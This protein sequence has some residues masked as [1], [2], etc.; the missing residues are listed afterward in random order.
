MFRLLLI[1]ILGI[2]VFTGCVSPLEKSVM[3]P[4]ESKEL[5]KVAGE[6]IS[7]LA[8]YSIVQDKW[9]RMDSSADSARWAPLS[10]ARLHS[11]IKTTESAQLNSPLF[12]KLRA[13]WEEM[14][15]SNNALADSL[16]IKW[17][18]YLEGNSPDS[19]VSVSLENIEFEKIRNIKKEID[20]LVKVQLKLRSAG[21]RIDSVK[22][23]YAF[24]R[25]FAVDSIASDTLE[26]PVQ[27]NWLFLQKRFTDSISVKVYPV[28][29]QQM[30]NLLINK[31]SSAMFRYALQSVYSD[32]IVY[33]IDTLQS[34][35]P[36]PVLAF[37]LA[38]KE[39]D[40]PVFDSTIY[41]E[42]IIK[43]LVNPNYISQGAYLRLNAQ[44][45][46]RQIDS[47]AFSY[48]NYKGDW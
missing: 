23:S 5:D 8:T 37:I 34:K 40:S 36:E 18:S 20:T 11:F 41:R 39:T 33:N 21:I 19:L 43:E 6:D 16:I 44:E 17:K 27:T 32:G 48:L 3:V 10:Y 30:K 4:L 2:L 26:Q 29:P 47:L 1:H 35:V 42:R 12:T 25:E 28:L 24:N 31:D 13:E 22:L 15:N 38:E 7:F 45:Y 9:N 46:Y 14:N